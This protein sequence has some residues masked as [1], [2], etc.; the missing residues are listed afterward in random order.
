MFSSHGQ[1]PTFI[2]CGKVVS[3]MRFVENSKRPPE[4]VNFEDALR[5]IMQVSKEDLEKIQ[6]EEEAEKA[7]KPRRGPKPKSK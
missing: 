6:A 7:D 5:Q 4:M 2:G 3:K 1:E